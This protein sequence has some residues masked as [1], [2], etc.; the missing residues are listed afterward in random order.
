[1]RKFLVT[2]TF[3]T[4]STSYAANYEPYNGSGAYI[5][6][7]AGWGAL[8]NL[9][10]GSFAFG[11]SAGYNFNRAFAVEGGWSNFASAQY[12]ATAF[13]NFYDVAVK[14]TLP[15]SKIF[16]LYGR[17][18]GG[19][20]TNSISGIATGASDNFRNSNG[21]ATFGAL[22]GIGGSFVLSRHFDLR[23]E[24]YVIIPIGSGGGTFG[25]SNAIMGGVQF[26]F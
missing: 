11:A 6:V 8:S 25:N 9:A 12:G 10:T 5:N 1:M 7:N 22:A 14:G 24:D 20:N 13:N 18:G 3:L 21:S 19:I 15:L 26:N 16:S 2:I 4:M 23:V 17:L